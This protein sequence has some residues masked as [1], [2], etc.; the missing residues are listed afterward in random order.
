M[1]RKRQ[2]ARKWE[3]TWEGEWEGAWESEGEGTRDSEWEG[4]WENGG[5]TRARRGEGNDS[6][7]VLDEAL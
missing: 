4:E 3:V 5:G 7:A 1:K 6:E 2:L